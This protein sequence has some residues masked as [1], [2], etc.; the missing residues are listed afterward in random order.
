MGEPFSSPS[1]FELGDFREKDR[2]LGG[3]GESVMFISGSSPFVRVAK[4]SLSFFPLPVIELIALDAQP[5]T[6]IFLPALS[7]FGVSGAPDV[8]SLS[9]RFRVTLLSER[10]RDDRD[11]GREI[12][13]FPASDFRRVGIGECCSSE[14]LDEASAPDAW[15][16]V[17]PLDTELN[18][19]SSVARGKTG[20]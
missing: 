15:E 18:L 2:E 13:P 7:T 14:P 8:T 9:E 4:L 10:L 20:G 11:D 5:V 17:D 1:A 16:V 12:V 6:F 19:P 3:R